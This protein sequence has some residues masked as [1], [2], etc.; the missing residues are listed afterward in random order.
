MDDVE[1]LFL[2]S[3][4]RELA[5]PEQI[6]AYAAAWV[7]RVNASA[8]DDNRRR[9]EI[10]KRL[11]EIDK[12]NTRMTKMLIEGLGDVLALNRKIKDQA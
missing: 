5:N 1:E 3:L 2:D 10:T 9:R 6:E 12:T 7:Q 11:A 8:D 4:T